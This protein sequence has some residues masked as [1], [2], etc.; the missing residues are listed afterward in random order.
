[1]P[2][3]DTMSQRSDPKTS[4]NE[5]AW[6]FAAR[7]YAADLERDIYFLR[8]GGVSLNDTEQGVLGNIPLNGRAVHLQC[9]HGLDTLS[10]I[11]LGFSDV[12]GVDLSG[13]MLELARRKS[14]ALGWSASWIHA[15]VLEPPEDTL[16]SADLVYTGKGAIPWIRS[17]GRWSEVVQRLLRPGGYLYVYESHPL[18]WIWEPGSVVHRMDRSRSYFDD[19][20]RPN[21]DFPSSAVKRYSP[22]DEQPPTA[23][24]YHYTLG[25]ILTATADAG[26]EF[27]QLT[28]HGEHFWDRFPEMPFDEMARLPHT[29]SLLARRPTA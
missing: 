9:S 24:E 7:K 22:S 6:D 11:N 2:I 19:R 27:I 20:P 5:A 23:W 25:H 3:D 17:I 10:L 26:L 4:S 29:F 18:D 8:A 15:D 16:G 13:A 1:M 12:I 14:D 21:E 28:E